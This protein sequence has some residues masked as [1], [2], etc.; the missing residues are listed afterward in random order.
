MP[1]P[2]K[3]IKSWPS[4]RVQRVKALA[5]KSDSWSL[6]PSTHM[7]EEES[8][9]FHRCAVAHACTHMPHTQKEKILSHSP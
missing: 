5:A 7:D 9:N 6:I 2:T 1:Y 8:S 4:E 3:D